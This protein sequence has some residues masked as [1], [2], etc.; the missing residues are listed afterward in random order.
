[1]RRHFVIPDTQVKPGVPLDHLEWIG[2]AIAEYEPDVVVCL[3]DWAD[4]E[5]LSS[6]AK[7]REAEGKRYA[8][9]T[10]VAEEAMRVLF[11][12]VSE[13]AKTRAKRAWKARCRWVLTL[14]NHEYRIE[15]AIDENPQLEGFMSMADLGYEKWG[16]E[17]YPFLDLVEIDGVTYCHY[18]Q[19]PVGRPHSAMIETRIRN[20][21]FSFVQ[22]HQQGLRV[23]SVPRNNGVVHRGV[24]AGS[25]YLHDEGYMAQANAGHWR[26]CVV[27]NDVH[28][29]TFDLMELSL[30]YLCRKYGGRG[31]H[32]WRFMKREYPAL[33]RT[34]SWLKLEELRRR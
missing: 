15:R 34:S 23:G 17:V 7:R 4:M 24:S 9:D 5:S 22:G 30:D 11:S 18:F 16:W 3:G 32:V 6:Y 21:G 31:E 8:H 13:N 19:N 27:L 14:G 1:M 26:G 10:A 12:A 25:A 29:G 28:G 2:A 33:Y 20:I